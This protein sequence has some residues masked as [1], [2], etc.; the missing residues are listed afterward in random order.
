MG[1]MPVIYGDNDCY[2]RLPEKLRWRFQSQGSV[3]SMWKSEDEWRC[4]GPLNLDA[5]ELKHIRLLT[6]DGKK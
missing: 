1:I 2:Q 3:E 4:F 5:Q 6:P